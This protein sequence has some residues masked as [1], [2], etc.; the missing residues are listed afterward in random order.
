MVDKK[1]WE[2]KGEE[3][4]AFGNFNEMQLLKYALF[5]LKGCVWLPRR[6]GK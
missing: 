1:V 3:I 6:C 5:Y 4:E 2:M